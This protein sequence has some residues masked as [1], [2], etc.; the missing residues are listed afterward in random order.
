M[1]EDDVIF[2]PGDAQQEILHG[3]KYYTLWT[4]QYRHKGEDEWGY[5]VVNNQTGISEA[6]GSNYPNSLVALYYLEDR[7]IAVVSDPEAE[8][9]RQK[10]E[11]KS[12][13]PALFG[14]WDERGGNGGLD[15]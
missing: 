6:E 1:S 12:G 13:F 8:M 5:L 15:S 2:G 4:G 3:L 11:F 14:E 7:Y 9:R 10:A